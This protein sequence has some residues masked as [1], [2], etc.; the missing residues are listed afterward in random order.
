MLQKH[1]VDLDG[2]DPQKYTLVFEPDKAQDH[3]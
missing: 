2:L 3:M 1:Q